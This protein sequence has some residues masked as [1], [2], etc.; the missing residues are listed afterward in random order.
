MIETATGRRH[1]L[2]ALGDY[3][4]E[5]RVTPCARYLAAR[6][7][8]G[9]GGGGT[10][11]TASCSCRSS[12][13]ARAKK[14]KSAGDVA[15]RTAARAAPSDESDRLAI[16]AW[17]STGLEAL[18]LGE[19]RDA[20]RRVQD[21]EWSRRSTALPAVLFAVTAAAVRPRGSEV[22]RRARRARH[23]ALDPEPRLA[24]PLRPAAAAG[25][26]A[27]A[28][29]GR[30]AAGRR[31]QRARCVATAPRCS[32]RA[33]PTRPSWRGSTLRR[34]STRRSRSGC[35]ARGPFAAHAWRGAGAQAAAAVSAA[36][37]TSVAARARA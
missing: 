7:K 5:L 31:A 10:A 37:M 8:H 17:A 1:R 22:L 28:P 15:R 4:V 11:S 23:L 36:A 27:G 16:P 24:G 30:P 29:E 21:G 14:K 33:T 13:T 6:D 20:W 2:D 19:A 32:G 3:P 34:R 12:C 18:V 9:G 26:A 25:D 35:A